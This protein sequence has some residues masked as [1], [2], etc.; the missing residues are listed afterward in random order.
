M[1]ELSIITMC[2]H[3]RDREGSLEQDSLAVSLV[4]LINTKSFQMC[5]I[6]G[7]ATWLFHPMCEHNLH[8]YEFE[9]V[10]QLFE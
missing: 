5:H 6:H 9:Y 2:V 1:Y 4:Q 10:Y 7:Y 3:K 8:D